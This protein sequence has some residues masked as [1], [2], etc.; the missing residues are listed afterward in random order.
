MYNQCQ[1]NAP[2]TCRIESLVPREDM[3]KQEHKSD[4]T[5]IGHG[6]EIVVMSTNN[7]EGHSAQIFLE[8]IFI[9]LK[10]V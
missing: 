6:Q 9:F 1:R 2:E 8:F 4:G 10:I 5:S 3:T 7:D